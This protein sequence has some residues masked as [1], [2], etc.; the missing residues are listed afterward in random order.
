MDNQG[1]SI[2]TINLNSDFPLAGQNNPSQGFRD[3]FTTIKQQ[4]ETAKLEITELSRYTTKAML[5]SAVGDQSLNND[6][7]FNQIIRAH[8]RSPVESYHDHGTLS[9]AMKIDF[10]QGTV[11]F[12]RL[13]GTA[14]VR[15]SNFPRGA[16]SARLTLLVETLQ[17][18][19]ELVFPS[20]AV[21]NSY[22]KNIIVNNRLAF[23]GPGFYLLDFISFANGTKMFLNT[24]G[25]F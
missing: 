6:L 25:G 19:L 14:L 18:T 24:S 10:Y 11:Q 20:G 21:E 13:S 15:F 1:S 22:Q 5:K 17:G 3:N 12:V 7:E 8:M 9:S 2:T 4:L 16:F 23:P